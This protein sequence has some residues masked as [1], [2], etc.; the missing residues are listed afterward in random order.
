MP[1]SLQGKSVLITGGAGFIGSHLVDRLAAES[2]KAV[3]VVDNEYLGREAN[4]ASGKALLGERLHYYKQDAGD[5]SAMEAILKK[6]AVEVVYDMAVIPLP[7]SLEDPLWCVMENT[8]LTTVVCELQRRGLFQSMVHFSS[9]EAYGSAIT[10]PITEEHP[11]VPSTPYAASKLAG[12]QVALSYY[13]TF[14]SDITCLRPFNNYGPRQNDKSFAGIIPIVINKV[15]AGETLTI[16]GDGLQTRDY[17][18][19]RDTADAAVRIFEEEEAIGKVMNIGSGVELTVNDL[20]ACLLD[21][22]GKPNH[23][24]VHGPNRLGDVRR[25]MAGTEKS[26]A[27]LGFSPSTSLLDGMR[28]TVEWYLKQAQA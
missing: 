4:L 12:D 2:P 9:S 7:A 15:L 26:R 8:R 10:V 21:I 28:E 5:I 20:V 1:K 11:Y 14:G 3:V 6:H 17:I 25:H 27:I 13:H 24:V 22:L 19:V 16:N 23:P 18:F